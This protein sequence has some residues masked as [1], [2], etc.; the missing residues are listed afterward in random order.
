MGPH[1]AH[2]ESSP[3]K[4]AIN[5]LFFIRPC[6]IASMSAIMLEIAL[7]SSL[8]QGIRAHLAYIIPNITLAMC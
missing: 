8:A 1:R 6:I 3:S 5:A 2:L 7:L 4:C